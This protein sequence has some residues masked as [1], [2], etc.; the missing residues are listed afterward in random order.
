MGKRA[1]LI[2]LDSVG[3]G[4][5]DDSFLYGDEG[6]NTLKHIASAV[7]GLNLPNMQALGLGNLEEL[8][9]VAAANM[10]KG[11]YGKMQEKSK[12]KDT[13][14]G[15]WEMMG[16][17]L[18]QAF[19]TYPEG[20]PANLIHELEQRIGR[21]TLGNIVASGTEIIK[22]LGQEHVET[23]YPIVY[24]SAD[25]VL[26]IAAHE[27]VIPLEELYNI[28]RIARELLTGE[29]GVGRVI[30][31]PFVG[32]VGNYTRTP[33]RHD[34]SLVPDRNILDCIAAAGK[35][36]V[37][38]GKIKDIFA[39]RGITESYTTENNREGIEKIRDIMKCNFEG[40]IF[41]NLVDFDQLYGHRNDVDGYAHSLEEFDLGL[42][43][44][45][46][47]MLPEDILFISADHGCDPTTPGTDH[48]RE[49]VPILVYGENIKSGLDLGVRQSFADLG[50]TIAEF[51][52]VE[53][54]NIAGQ[55]FYSLIKR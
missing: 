49:Q 28:C 39:G 30:A 13:T 36:V 7:G 46:E 32:Q 31:R 9:G 45:V 3:I 2:I 47:S 19:P 52:E 35:K 11:S 8:E 55:S 21:K 18:D 40:L 15:H 10:P 34:F 53:S 24:T 43:G 14:T 4:A 5:V 37:G 6:C 41:I 1:I 42:P 23:G 17:V 48:T 44:I 54:L 33:H 20:F 50:Q 12:G 25:S 29:H 27:E 38:V 16:L 51:L 22:I 26:Q